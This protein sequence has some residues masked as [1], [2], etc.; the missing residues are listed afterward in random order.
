[1]FVLFNFGNNGVKMVV[2]IATSAL[3]MDIVDES[4]RTGKYIRSFATYSRQTIYF[5]IWSDDRNGM[6]GVDRIYDNGSSAG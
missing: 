5:S 6:C 4:D 3:R 2:S 1:M